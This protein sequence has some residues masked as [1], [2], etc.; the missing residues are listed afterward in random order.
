MSSHFIKFTEQNNTGIIKLNRPNALNALNYEMAVD[1]LEILSKWKTTHS[2]KRVLLLG[3]GEA[4]CVGGDVKSL[5]SS[6]NKNNLKETFFQKEY[7]LNYNINEFPKKYLSVWNGL[8]MGGGVGLS[9]Y[10]NYRLATEKAKF[11]MPETAIGFFPDVGGSYFLSQL[12]NGI[13]TYLGLTG[14]VLNARDMMDLELATHYLPSERLTKTIDQYIEKGNINPSSYYPE[15]S[16]DITENKNFIEDTFQNDLSQIMKKLKNSKEEFG[17]KI[18]HHLL[19][20]C[21]MSL[22]VS[23]KLINNA[24]SKSLKECL[25]IEYQLSQHMVYRNDFNN[26]VDAVLVSKNHQPQWTPSNI[27]EIN[28]DE[29]NKMFEPHVKKLYL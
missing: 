5:F 23:I 22:A 2:I 7:T 10:G 29:V 13:G 18:Y 15:M 8:V 17:Q 16:S 3:E 24:K 25:K 28:Y 20:R 19:S 21:P 12:K 6:S 26:G 4:F 11:A 14:K 9:I 27:D 1:F